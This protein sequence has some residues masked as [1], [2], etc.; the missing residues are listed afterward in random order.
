[1]S[2]SSNLVT[3]GLISAGSSLLGNLFN[4]F[5]QGQANSANMKLAEYQY[6]KNLEQ[7]YRQNEYNLPVNQ[8]ARLRSAGINPVMA[9]SGGQVS[10]NVANSSPDY[11]APQLHP[12][13]V[14]SSGLSDIGQMYIQARTADKQLQLM[15][16]Q[17]HLNET[18]AATE[19]MV[20]LLRELQSNRQFMENQYYQDIYPL[21]KDT[22]KANLDLL[23]SRKSYTDISTDVLNQELQ[24]FPYKVAQIEASIRSLDA[25]TRYKILEAVS[26]GMQNIMDEANIQYADSYAYHRHLKYI[27]D[28]VGSGKINDLRDLKKVFQLIQNEQLPQEFRLKMFKVISDAIIKGAPLM[29]Y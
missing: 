20:A 19:N 27:N 2:D 29:M 10:G 12:Y 15:E 11:Q 7:W 8:M 6:Q 25:G 28:A 4:V 5:G 9:F 3:A 24:M 14:D 13:Q 23:G 17:V 18:K 21:L 16:S 26:L 1:M 22:V